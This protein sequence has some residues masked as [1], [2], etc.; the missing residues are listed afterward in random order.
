MRPPESLCRR[1]RRRR[2][3][4]RRPLVILAS[5]A[6]AVIIAVFAAV[7]PINR[8]F[9]CILQQQI[10]YRSIDIH[11]K[12]NRFAKNRR[13]CH[14]TFVLNFFLLTVQI[15]PPCRRVRSVVAR[16]SRN[17]AR[18]CCRSRVIDQLCGR[19]GWTTTTIITPSLCIGIYTPPPPPADRFASFTHTHDD[20]RIRRCRGID[21]EIAAEV[22]M[23]RR[24]RRRRLRPSS[25][26]GQHD[27]DNNDGQ[28]SAREFRVR[29]A[30]TAAAEVAPG[31]ARRRC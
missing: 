19:K 27:D 18:R 21:E 31:T 12:K 22:I 3:R 14:P 11:V 26:D 16:R 7:N 9:V 4:R 5:Q 17:Q 10:G 29:T 15:L 13:N 23:I 20:A 24:R 30:S 28:V 1:R 6:A 25:A 8:R 2:C